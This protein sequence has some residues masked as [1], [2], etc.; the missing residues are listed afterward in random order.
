M[1]KSYLLLSLL[2]AGLC[3][4]AQY[5]HSSYGDNATAFNGAVTRNG[6]IG[7]IIAGIKDQNLTIARTDENGDFTQPENFNYI[8][9]LTDPNTSQQLTVS[10]AFVLELNNGSGHIAIG[11]YSTGS[12]YGIFYLPLDM[13]GNPSGTVKG[14][15]NPNPQLRV[16][17]RAIT[18][19]VNVQGDIYAAGTTGDPGNPND[20]FALRL[21]AGGNVM[22]NCIYDFSFFAPDEEATVA[23]MTEGLNGE[24]MIVGGGG[25]DGLWLIVDQNDGN[26]MDVDL[27]DAGRTERFNSIGISEDPLSQGYV[28]SGTGDIDFWNAQNQWMNRMLGL[29]TDAARNAEWFNYYFVESHNGIEEEGIDLT[30]RMN[31]LGNYE[32]FLTG[33]T[34][35]N[36]AP[37][38]NGV[39]LRLEHDG[40]VSSMPMIPLFHYPLNNYIIR[41]VCAA[42]SDNGATTGLSLYSTAHDQTSGMPSMLITKVYFNGESPCNQSQGHD[43]A[44]SE[45]NY[46]VNNIHTQVIGNLDN[47]HVDMNNQ[48][49]S[50]YFNICFAGSIPG[51]SNDRTAPAYSSTPGGI[52]VYPN[53]VG[54]GTDLH[55][56][57][58]TEREEIVQIQITDLSGRTLYTG[59][60]RTLPG[61]NDL[62][63]DADQLPEVP[64]IY[65][66]T[67]IRAS[68]TERLKISV[69]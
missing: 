15:I 11:S 7:H 67:V 24:L 5:F 53:P 35:D 46:R 16:E 42:A 20:I 64:G 61:Y 38:G 60:H 68:Q 40:T 56:G 45:L 39:V 22:W 41:P 14:F 49:G 27:Y 3:A 26:P 21:D 58:N 44:P 63:A 12:D 30:G 47:A 34:Y 18:E 6:S 50:S 32:Y 36:G 48:Y 37:S 69:Q 2:L 43:V 13:Q 51:G 59:I 54:R 57:V 31:T 19:S 55:I 9:E 25:R 62:K 4:N 28:L 23:D 17:V 52:K 33:F 8:Y 1:K 66:L 29:K 65:G 10:N